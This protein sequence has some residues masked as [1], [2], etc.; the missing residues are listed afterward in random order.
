MKSRT[1]LLRILCPA[2]L[3]P[4][5]SVEGFSFRAE[6]QGQAPEA[7]HPPGRRQKEEQG[8]EPQAAEPGGQGAA[9]GKGEG[10]TAHGRQG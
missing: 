3:F 9:P 7:R 6:G 10:R 2:G 5:F 4:F 8:M 1:G